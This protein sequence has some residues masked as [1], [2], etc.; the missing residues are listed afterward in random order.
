MNK[1]DRHIACLFLLYGAP[2]L[3]I[4]GGLMLPGP[5]AQDGKC[6]SAM[7]RREPDT[8]YR[9]QSFVSSSKVCTALHMVSREQY[10]NFPWKFMPPVNRLGQGSPM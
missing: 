1:K 10:S 8:A 7:G 6:R 9:P 5:F 3:R 4:G 2:L